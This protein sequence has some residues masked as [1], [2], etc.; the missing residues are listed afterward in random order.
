[1]SDE[2]ISTLKDLYSFIKALPHSKNIPTFSKILKGLIFKTD[3][4]E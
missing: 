4:T 3:M 2:I 1:M